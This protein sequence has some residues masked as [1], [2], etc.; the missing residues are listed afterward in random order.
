MSIQHLPRYAI[1]T[2]AR[3]EEDTI[4][5]TLDSI[6]SQTIPP[7]RWIIVDDG[8][9]DRTHEI[10]ARY[11]ERYPWI[12]LVRRVNPGTYRL[13]GGVVEAFYE[14]L[15]H[16]DMD[17]V[18]F[19]CKL[20]A[21]LI[22]K[23]DHF[24]QLLVRAAN[25][26]RLGIISGVTYFTREGRR[27]VESVPAHHAI[28][29]ARMWRIACFREIEGLV[30]ALGWDALDEMR[31]QMHGWVSRSYPELEILHLRPMSSKQG[32]YKGRYK[33]GL[34]DYLLG[35]HPLFEVARCSYRMIHRPYLVG[36]LLILLGYIRA[37]IRSEKQI[38]TPEERRFLQKQQLSRLSRGKIH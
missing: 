4:A 17:T 12:H 18:E 38:T 14:G 37:A 20:D 21:D 15:G 11:A 1:I 25:D 31:A 10:V 8:S 22:L 7:S 3:D 33:N 34:T 26:A 29:A 6:V 36:G 13:G 30:P 5:M 9:T 28:G 2:P 16:L 27:V 24:E 35:Y 23:V 19:I 32:W